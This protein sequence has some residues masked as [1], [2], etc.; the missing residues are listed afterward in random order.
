LGNNSIVSLDLRAMSVEDISVGMRLST[1]AGWNQVD[2]DWRFFL[3]SPGSGGILAIRDARPVGTVA[4]VRYDRLAWIA[5]MLV[6]PA[7]RRAG[8]GA[9]LMEQALRALGDAE[10]VGL[11]ATPLGEPLYRH[12]GLTNHYTLV[13]TK[14]TVSSARFAPFAGDAHPMQPRDL[15]DVFAYDCQVFGADRSALLAALWARAPE[16]AWIVRGADSLRGYSFGRNGRLF[17]Q[18]GPVVADDQDTARQLTAA[19]FS[20]LDGRLFAIDAPS[21]DAEWLGWLQST[22]F[23][24]ERPFVRMFL[25]G[26]THPGLPARQYAI[27]GPEFA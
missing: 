27:T 23:A 16:C 21:F 7:E 10:C 13:R 2:A 14:A 22:G 18:L 15:A 4:F 1:S 25:A 17:H 6:D 5:M 12:Y 11:D 24:A 9:H 19:C 26:H 20:G 8:I 3:E